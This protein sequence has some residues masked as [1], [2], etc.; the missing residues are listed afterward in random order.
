M[1]I[2]R[3]ASGL[4]YCATAGDV[5]GKVAIMVGT[6]TAQL[7][8]IWLLA[9][10]TIELLNFATWFT[11]IPWVVLIAFFALYLIDSWAGSPQ[12]VLDLEPFTHVPWVDGYSTIVPLL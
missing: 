9:A 10:V 11:P 3:P 7:P 4:V 5:D 8:A 1:L 2:A 6:A 12:W